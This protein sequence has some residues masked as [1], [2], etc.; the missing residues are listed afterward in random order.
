[1]TEFVNI[2]IQNEKALVDPDLKELINKLIL[3][4][5]KLVFTEA[6]HASLYDYSVRYS[7]GGN[8]EK[9]MAPEEIGRAHV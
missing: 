2:R 7:W 8:K 3:I 4:N 1:M 5:P 9:Y 6:K